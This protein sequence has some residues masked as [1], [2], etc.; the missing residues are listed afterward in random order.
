[1]EDEIETD[2]GEDPQ[3]DAGENVEEGNEDENNA[4]VIWFIAVIS[5]DEVSKS[6]LDFPGHD[7][8]IAGLKNDGGVEADSNITEESS[9]KLLLD[10]WKLT[11]TS[12]KQS[13]WSF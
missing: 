1:M 2:E 9:K 10:E 13:S 6:E 7:G 3:D 8:E 4:V 11:G 5:E 12:H